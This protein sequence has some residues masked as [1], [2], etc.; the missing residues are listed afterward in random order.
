VA[1]VV[2]ILTDFFGGADADGER[3]A[4]AALPALPLLETLL[5]RAQ[6]TTLQS[7]W[8]GWLAAHAAGA[9]T[10][11]PGPDASLAQTVAAAFGADAP[12][13]QAAGQLWLASPVHYFAGL[14]SVFLHPAG[15]LNLDGA[16]QDRLVADFARVF[17][18]S[19]WTLRSIGR[20]DLLL[21]GPAIAASSADPA[22]F[23][24]CDPSAGLPSGVGSATL[25]GLGAEMEMWLYEHPLN[26][27][28][29]GRGELPVTTFWLWG[30]QQG[31][32]L[33]A[34]AGPRARPHSQ[35][36]QPMQ[37]SQPV[38]LYGRDTYAEA[39]WRLQ[40]GAM[41]P[42]PEGFDAAIIGDG[43]DAIFLHSLLQPQGLSAALLQFEQH[44]LSGALRLLR[45]RRIAV[46][47]LLVGTHAYA[48]RW[49]HLARV[50][51]P[52][53]AWWETLA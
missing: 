27:E 22:Q 45:Q 35:P 49:R 11:P 52:R 39:L 25:R 12:A 7:D 40:G 33:P 48:L 21:A 18:A 16:E 15:L 50:W 8:R 36:M 30:A 19:P 42:L 17:S 43:G 51:R 1:E 10:H 32:R 53:T 9:P 23:A 31:R 47:R 3:N 29:R 28:R 5:A 46:L 26:I 14:D 13:R 4:G 41:L 37:A 6:R 20:R 24:G 34:T 2:F 44:W 38:R